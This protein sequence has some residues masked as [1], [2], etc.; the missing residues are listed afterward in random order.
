MKPGCMFVLIKQY[1]HENE[2]YKLHHPESKAFNHCRYYGR[3]YSDYNY[4][5]P[6]KKQI[7]K[8][9][10]E[11]EIYPHGTE[12]LMMWYNRLIKVT[13]EHIKILYGVNETPYIEYN[14]NWLDPDD[15][16]KHNGTCHEN[17]LFEN[18]ELLI[19]SLIKRYKASLI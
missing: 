18:R 7:M 1:K 5:L 9:K 15:Y 19:D 3:Y 14:V 16:E 17:D 6:F 2:N 8:K 10:I 13:V 12:L 11:F 4:L